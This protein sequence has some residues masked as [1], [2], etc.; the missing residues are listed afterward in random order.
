MGENNCTCHCRIHGHLGERDDRQ[1]E[2]ISDLE[3]R[4]RLVST[5]L[6]ARSSLA[7]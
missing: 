3:F 7:N 2:R 4:L 1:D 6:G 5:A